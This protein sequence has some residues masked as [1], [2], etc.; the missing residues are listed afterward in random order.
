MSVTHT[1]APHDR[2]PAGPPITLRPLLFLCGAMVIVGLAMALNGVGGFFGN[3]R[4]RG[5]AVFDHGVLDPRFGPFVAM[6]EG[7]LGGSLVGK[8]LAAGALLKLADPRE[9]PW[10]RRALLGALAALG[11]FEFGLLWAWGIPPAEA[12]GELGVAGIVGLMLWR[13]ARP[14]SERPAPA[15][16]PAD[17]RPT[18][19]R[20]LE[21]FAWAMVAFGILLG[22]AI[23][24]PP[25]AVYRD[26]M[27]ALWFE[28]ALPH[29]TLPWM[30]YGFGAIGA[31]FAGHFLVL[32]AVARH[33][34]AE[35]WAA[36]VWGGTV[37][38]WFAVDSAA[39]LM[40]GAT[41]NVLMVNLPALLG[42]GGLLLWA[43]KSKSALRRQRA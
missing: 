43:H 40:Q 12:M 27:A 5:I 24:S 26:A 14:S 20:A 35:P 18:A 8:W 19:W 34:W 9:H 28:G 32:A 17:A 11:V 39:C 37:L 21:A 1:P 25:F 41:F 3:W 22:V 10:A 36:R 16:G 38:A 30:Q 13:T 2:P 42:S 15:P 7:I 23:I 6:L 4:A 33:A 29:G 31:A